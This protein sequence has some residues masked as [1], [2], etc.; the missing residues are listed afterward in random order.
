MQH[1]EE[2]VSKLT[3]KNRTQQIRPEKMV[4]QISS[5]IIGMIDIYI[6]PEENADISGDDQLALL[7]QRIEEDEIQ[8]LEEKERIIMK[9][10]KLATI[11]QHQE[12]DK[13]QKLMEKENWAMT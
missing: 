9:D 12:E 6:P 5:G 10:G 11:M 4:D 7:L 8:N 2:N 13:A 3:V 1:E